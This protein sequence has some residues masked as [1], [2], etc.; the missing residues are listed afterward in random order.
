MFIAKHWENNI[1][2][3]ALEIR[4]EDE[5]VLQDIDE[6]YS[7]VKSDCESNKKNIYISWSPKCAIHEILF[8]VVAEINMDDKKFIIKHLVQSPFWDSKQ[9]E[10]RHLKYALEDLVS[11]FDELSLDMREL[12]EKNMRIALD[13]M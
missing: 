1:L 13:W 3:T 6:F 8:I 10:S 2:N 5:H 11:D 12:Y 9:I 4:K 7:I